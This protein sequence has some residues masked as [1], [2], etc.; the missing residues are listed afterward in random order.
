VN[1]MWDPLFRD[2]PLPMKHHPTLDA[3]FV[4]GPSLGLGCLAV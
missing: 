2:E 1:I 4:D 3:L